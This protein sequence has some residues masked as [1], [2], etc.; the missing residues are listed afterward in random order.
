MGSPR[1]GA[2]HLRRGTALEA[3]GAPHIPARCD[4]QWPAS[5]S[6]TRQRYGRVTRGMWMFANLFDFFIG[7][8]IIFFWITAFMIWFQCFF[9][10]W[11]RDDLS[12][13]MKAVWTV[14][15]LVLPWL[16]ALI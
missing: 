4:P 13:G 5:R 6:R 3:A 1:A 10:A 2:D 12:G 9:D 16:G 14:V 11:R 7:M 8:L 15:M